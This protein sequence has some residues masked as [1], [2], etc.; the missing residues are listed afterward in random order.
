MGA[1]CRTRVVGALT[2]DYTYEKYV[3]FR[4]ISQNQQ[5]FRQYARLEQVEITSR[6]SSDLKIQHGILMWPNRGKIT[7]D[8]AKINCT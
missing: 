6:A 8:C 2:C 5:L 4:K 1:W 7:I 3:I